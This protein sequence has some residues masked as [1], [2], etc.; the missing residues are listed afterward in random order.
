VGRS[1]RT[2]TVRLAAAGLSLSLAACA[3]IP[4]RVETQAAVP[5]PSPVAADG[6]SG[7]APSAVTALIAQS[8]EARESGNYATADST[9]ERA[10]RI[11]PNSAPLWLEYARLRLSEGDLAQADSLARK[12]MSLAGDDRVTRD[13]AT[14]LIAGIARA[15]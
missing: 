1:H 6:A 7:E 11:E 15:K 13:A 8:R 5:A 12:A 9:L 3:G 2:L 14:Q 10:L 4:G